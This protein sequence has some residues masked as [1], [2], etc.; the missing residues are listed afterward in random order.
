MNDYDIYMNFINQ[1]INRENT[2]WIKK[3][4]TKDYGKIHVAIMVEPFLSYILNGEKTIESRFSK[5][6]ISPF[7]KV[8]RK[9]IIFLKQSGGGI[10]AVFEAGEVLS[11]D[12]LDPQKIL[13]LRKHYNNRICGSEEFWA[14]KNF[15]V[16]ATLIE[17]KELFSLEE[18]KVSGKNRQ[19]WITLDTAI[20]HNPDIA[21]AFYRAGYIENQGHGIQ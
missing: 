5:K 8:E 10:R 21:K 12:Q 16:Y 14:R 11:F 20:Q 7:E 15:S 4:L 19:S 2:Y 3:V 9:D 1:I 13:D 17:I 18:I 6:R